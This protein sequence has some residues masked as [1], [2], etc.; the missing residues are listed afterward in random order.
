MQADGLSL[1]LTQPRTNSRPSVRM[2]GCDR[3]IVERVAP[4]PLPERSGRPGNG[5][6]GLIDDGVNVR[7]VGAFDLQYADGSFA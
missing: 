6:A 3:P 4:K 7:L 5:K 2:I 1:L